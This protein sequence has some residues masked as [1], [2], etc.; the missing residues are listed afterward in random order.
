MQNIS[1]I[2]NTLLGELKGRE[3][4]VLDGRFGIGKNAAHLTLAALGNRYGVTRERIRQIESSALATLRKKIAEDSACSEVVQGN[5]KFLAKS[6]GVAKKD[7]LLAYN[8]EFIDGITENHIA[9]VLE[10]S[11]AA[12]FH[13]EDSD[14]WPFYYLERGSAKTAA[15]FVNQLTTFLRGKKNEALNGRYQELFRG[16]LKR[17]GVPEAHA[18]NYV[19]I[20]KKTRANSYGDVGLTEWPEIKPRTVRDRVYLVLKKRKTPLHFRE[21]AKVI[22]ENGL[23]PRF[24]SAPTVHNELIKDD[25]FVL[26]GRGT[27][28]LQEYGYEPGTAREVIHKILKK[29]GAMKP[30][31]VILAIQ[32]ER[33]FKPNTILVNL[34]NKSFFK[35]LPD[36]T[37]HIRES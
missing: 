14:F 24:A 30:R 1:K 22:N 26:V 10:A 35:R 27:Y 8:Q 5:K 32:K 7:A 3:R 28:A 29:Q 20:S 2:L 18:V 37:Y 34:Q 4:E 13:P 9:L 31:E 15:A 6:G 16:F 17:T 21:I 11:H 23:S 25:R 36:G 19:G 33:F 12:L